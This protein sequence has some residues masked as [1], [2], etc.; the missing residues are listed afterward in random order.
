MDAAIAVY[1]SV[2]YKGSRL[3]MVPYWQSYLIHSLLVIVT[4]FEPMTF[5]KKI[6][7]IFFIKFHFYELYPVG[8]IITQRVTLVKVVVEPTMI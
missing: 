3:C 8:F 5:V 1:V 4:G 6:G 7:E 2:W